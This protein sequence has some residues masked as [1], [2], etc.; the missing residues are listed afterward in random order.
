MI[1]YSDKLDG[2]IQVS[3]SLPV[4]T[5]KSRAKALGELY[6]KRLGLTEVL[7]TSVREVGSYTCYVAYGNSAVS[8]DLDE[9]VSED[10]EFTCRSK[11]Q[12]EKEATD[13]LRPDKKVLTVVGAALESD[14]H[15][16]GLDAILNPKGYRGDSGLERYACF[17]VHNL[18][19]QVEIPKLLEYLVEVNADVL[20][21]SQ[22][23]SQNNIH[24]KHFQQLSDAINSAGLDITIVIG[25]M[26]VTNKMATSLG[27]LA[28]FGRD[29][30]PSMVASV[31]MDEMRIR[32][33]VLNIPLKV[34][35]PVLVENSAVKEELRELH[36]KERQFDE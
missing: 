34:K 21:V 23:V 9:V 33:G 7:I 11:D 5:D 35:Q 29:T 36:L 25:G 14:A 13:F 26:H 10:A 20:L 15:T 28:G 2:R 3:F 24:V 1:A 19:A 31:I 22:T 6:C 18:G 32:Y 27:F 8:V 17:N 4:A 12:I 16:V 30:T